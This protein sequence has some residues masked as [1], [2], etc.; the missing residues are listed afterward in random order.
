MLYTT[1]LIFLV[2][3]TEF[4]EFSPNRVTI[5]STS[6]NSILCS[7]WQF[8]NKI[9]IIKINKKRMIICDKVF[10][11][12]YST[13][14]MK[15]LHTFDVGLIYLGKLALSSNTEKNIV[16]FSS[17][18]DE[19]TVRVF[20]LLL[21][22]YKSTFQAH[23]SPLLKLNISSSGDYLCT[24]SCKGTTINVF[25]LPK[26]EI[27]ATFKRG[28]NSAYIFYMSFNLSENKLIISTDTGVINLFTISKKGDKI[29]NVYKNPIIDF[30]QKAFLSITALI[31]SSRYDDYYS[32]QNIN[33]KCDFLNGSNIILFSGKEDKEVRIFNNI[34]FCALILKVLTI[35]LKLIMTQRK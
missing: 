27:I 8:N 26:G 28:I 35:H 33:K 18:K 14:D 21:L 32:S 17:N 31:C 15:I 23:K 11:N 20:D 24:C 25:T 22:T 34:S 5:W 7:S 6:T 10:M 9:N 12:V 29:S 4:G 19:G 16:C 30:F 3:L 2:G 13:M 1:N